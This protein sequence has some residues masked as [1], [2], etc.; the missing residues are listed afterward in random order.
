MTKSSL[1]VDHVTGQV[2]PSGATGT[3]AAGA[4]LLTAPY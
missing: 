1:D 2:A 3:F 4:L